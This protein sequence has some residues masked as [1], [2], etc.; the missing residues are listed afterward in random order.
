LSGFPSDV[1]THSDYTVDELWTLIKDA[2][3]L[4]QPCCCSVNNEE[5]GLT[6]EQIK[7]A[8]LMNTHAYSLIE[9][10]EVINHDDNSIVR[11]VFIRNPYADNPGQN[12]SRWNQ[13][14]LEMP[15]NVKE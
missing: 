1:L 6:K 7:Q 5:S 3:T 10:K 8:G 9:A 14:T 2:A 13:T 11:V 12:V 4:D 15:N